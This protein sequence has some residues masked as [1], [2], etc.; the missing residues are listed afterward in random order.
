MLRHYF[1]G[2]TGSLFGRADLRLNSPSFRTP[3]TWVRAKRKPGLKLRLTDGRKVL[4]I[5][6]ALWRET[7][8]KRYTR[9]AWVEGA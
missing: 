1:K 3:A 7:H 5:A 8:V 2:V 9:A 6:G 4:F